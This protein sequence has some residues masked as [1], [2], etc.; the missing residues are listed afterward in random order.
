M[1]DNTLKFINNKK[2]EQDLFIKK[3]KLLASY[4]KIINKIINIMQDQ[5]SSII[6]LLIQNIIVLLDN[7]F[8]Y[9]NKQSNIN[10]LNI[11]HYISVLC[12][13]VNTIQKLEK[14]INQKNLQYADILIECIKNIKKNNIIISAKVLADMFY[15]IIPYNIISYERQEIKI[16]INYNIMIYLL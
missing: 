13:V 12:T 6:I 11:E 3:T 9:I 7:I 5:K 4:K 15:D 8:D 1:T 2:I 14:I 16:L 10:S